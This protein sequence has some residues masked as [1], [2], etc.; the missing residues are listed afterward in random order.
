MNR[1]ESNNVFTTNCPSTSG[2]KYVL[3]LPP[4][5]QVIE[6]THEEP[7][8]Y[9]GMTINF[10]IKLFGFEEQG[11]IDIVSLGDNLK[12]SYNANPD[13]EYFGLNLKYYM[14]SSEKVISNYYDFRK[15]FGVWTFISVSTFNETFKNYFPPMVRFEIN[16][17][18]CQLLD[19]WIT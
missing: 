9:T 17:K 8:N 14:G 15:H 10:F 13:H 5:P 3:K 2:G 1:Q 12:I 4:A 11:E 6:L 18:K 16:Q 7:Q 19:L